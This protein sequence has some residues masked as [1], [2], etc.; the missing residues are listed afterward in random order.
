MVK[1]R[2]SFSKCMT[3]LPSSSFMM[4]ETKPI[5]NFTRGVSPGQFS[6]DV[7]PQFL[8][9]YC[10]P[11]SKLRSQVYI[12]SLLFYTVFFT[13]CMQ[14]FEL[15]ELPGITC[16]HDSRFLQSSGTLITVFW[17]CLRSPRQICFSALLLSTLCSMIRDGIGFMINCFQ[18]R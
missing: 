3:L 15:I 11:F 12:N 4:A 17:H 2:D 14:C 6:I 16:I 1:I 10:M 8:T 18:V 13:I 7:F 5:L 9:Y